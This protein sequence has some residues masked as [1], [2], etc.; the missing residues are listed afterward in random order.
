MNALKQDLDAK[1]ALP[2]GFP[3]RRTIATACQIASHLRDGFPKGSYRHLCRNLARLCSNNGEHIRVKDGVRGALRLSAP[4]VSQLQQ[5]DSQ[6]RQ[7]AEHSPQAIGTLH[8]T[9]ARDG[10]PFSNTGESLLL[11]SGA[12][13]TRRAPKLALCVVVGTEGSLIHSK[14]SSPAGVCS[15]HTRMAHISSGSLPQRFVDR[16]AVAPSRS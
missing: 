9:L 5:T 12:H 6:G 10:I 3:T 8:L 14:G 11:P 2:E 13:T 15:S 1:P 16:A 7:Q 4:H